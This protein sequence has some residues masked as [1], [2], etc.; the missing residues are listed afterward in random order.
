MRIL[1]VCTLLGRGKK[2]TPLLFYY[3]GCTMQTLDE[4]RVKAQQGAG[5]RTLGT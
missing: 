3:K 4:V 1:A 5:V 2:K